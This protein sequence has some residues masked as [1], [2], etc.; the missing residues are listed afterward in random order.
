MISEMTTPINKPLNTAPAM[1]E[2]GRPS[3]GVGYFFSKCTDKT[4]RQLPIITHGMMSGIAD[5]MGLPV[6]MKDVTGVITDMAIAA[7]KP[8]VRTQIIR[9]VLIIGPVIYTDRFLK[10][11]L[12]MQ[13]A[14][15]KAA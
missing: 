14:S 5:I 2:I 12:T 8:A 4:S 11:W 6:I 7:H 3:L 9:Q 15:S 1:I 10:N 13:I